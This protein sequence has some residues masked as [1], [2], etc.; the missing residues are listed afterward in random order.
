MPQDQPTFSIVIPTYNRPTQLRACLASLT[1]LTYPRDRFEVVVVDDGSRV[2]LEPVV[3]PFRD[4]LDLRLI[5]Q[6]N[7]G[8][9]AARNTG[10]GYARGT[11]LAFTDDDCAPAPDWLDA[12]ATRFAED[13]DCLIGGRTVNALVDNPFA[14]ASQHLISYLYSYY[15][16]DPEQARFFASN[17]I[18]MPAEGFH[19]VAG[20]DVTTLRATAE[21]RELCDRWLYF[22]H[23]LVYAPEVVVYHAHAMGFREFWRQ[24]FN[25]GRGA[26]Y[27]HRVRTQRGLHSPTPE[28]P[29]FYLN[30]LR[31]PLRQGRGV[32]AMLHVLLMGVSQMANA[33]GFFWETYQEKQREESYKVRSLEPASN[34]DLARE[35]AQET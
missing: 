26:L 11:F 28:P 15:N 32:S 29:S 19:E 24:H 5:T 22:G 8:P 4:A 27:F 6:P 25:Y 34:P 35:G 10:A 3:A 30:L 1:R 7:G 31:Y 33:A 12:L 18:A 20:F 16:A 9:A 21:D 2:S 13:A 23:R 17:N 14:S